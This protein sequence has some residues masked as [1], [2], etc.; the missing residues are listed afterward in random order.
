MLPD[1]PRPPRYRYRRGQV[2]TAEMIGAINC[3][4]IIT[5]DTASM[6]SG[7]DDPSRPR[8]RAVVFERAERPAAGARIDREISAP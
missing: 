4:N 3:A 1:R 7:S 6:L 2:I 8:P 5:S